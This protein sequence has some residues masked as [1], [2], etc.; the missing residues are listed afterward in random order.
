MLR[1]KNHMKTRW[2]P[3]ALVG[4]LF[5]L[6]GCQSTPPKPEMPDE[7]AKPIS[8]NIDSLHFAEGLSVWGG[9]VGQEKERSLIVGALHDV[10]QVG[11]WSVDSKRTLRPVG[12]KMETGYHPDDVVRW[13]EDTFLVVVE[14]DRK[15]QFWQ[16]GGIALK[17][18]REMPSD[19]PAR[20]A[21]AAD[22]DGDG[23]K[24]FVI[25]PYD[26]SEVTIYWGLG[27]L[28]FSEPQRLAAAQSAWHPRIVDFDGDGRLDLLWSELDSGVVRLYLNRG[29]RA[30]EERVLAEMPNRVPR[31]LAASDLTGNGLYDLVV[32]TEI[33]GSAVVLIQE[34]DG[35]FKEEAIPAPVL[36]YVST[37]VLDDDG[38]PTVALGEEGRVVLA[39][40]VGPGDWA[41]RELPAGSMPS[42]LEVADVDQDGAEDLVIYHSARD[43]IRIH[44]GPLWDRASEA[45]WVADKTDGE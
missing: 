33:G 13:N 27:G 25:G 35:T 2:A 3:I 7:T 31:S 23:F 42:S 6:T 34:A 11:A 26:G 37:A 8:A 12:A 19:F 30:F 43:G 41:V 28:E 14:G 18:L 39:R 45:E 9:A 29:D 4:G 36:G 20:G 40:R 17:L 21:A 24:D 1:K 22:L 32:A 10:D 5:G 44:F 16:E 15:I 38:V